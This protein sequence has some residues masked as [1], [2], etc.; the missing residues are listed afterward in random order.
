[1]TCQS[2]TTA[3]YSIVLV[4]YKTLELTKTCLMLLQDALRGTGVPVIVVDNNSDDESSDYLRTVDWIQLL[5]RKSPYREPGN[6]AHGRAL[7]LALEHV[8]TDYLFLL[9][10]DTFIYDPSVFT[11]MISECSGARE[12]AAVG[13]LEQLDRG[14]A[15]STWRL[16]SRF[17]KH[18]SRRSLLALGIEVRAPK[19]YRE[20]HLKSFCTLWN[21]ALIKKHGFHFQMDDRNPGYEL[22]DRMVA[23]GYQIGFISPRKMF[24]YLDH[25]QSGTVAAMGG[26][27]SSHRRVKKYEQVTQQRTLKAY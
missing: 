9:H 24:T 6:I 14:V 23:R 10:S 4:N 20:K 12:V 3:N 13:C 26:Y 17:F 15:R 25:I 7:D 22:Q 11:M 27:S 16:I 21:A 19:P 18:Y 1:M 5:E 8:E 2:S